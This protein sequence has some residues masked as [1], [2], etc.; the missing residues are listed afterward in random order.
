[1]LEAAPAT[2]V[3]AVSTAA[4]A[5]GAVQ[6]A[7]AKTAATPSSVTN[8]IPETSGEVTPTIPTWTLASIL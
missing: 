3:P 2:I 6:S 7:T 8:V 1:M 4:R 5:P